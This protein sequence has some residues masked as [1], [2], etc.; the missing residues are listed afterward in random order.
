M[1]N[2]LPFRIIQEEMKKLEDLASK[3][4][5]ICTLDHEEYQ[6]VIG[7]IFSTRKWRYDVLPGAYS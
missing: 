6:K 5:A 7:E 3:S 1:M 2:M 4:L